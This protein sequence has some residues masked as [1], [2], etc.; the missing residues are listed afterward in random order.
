LNTPPPNASVDWLVIGSG[1]AGT[2]AARA[3]VEQGHHVTVL[4][5]G[6]RLD[7]DREKIVRRMA[8]LRPS[9]WDSEDLAMVLGRRR[10]SSEAVHSKLSYGSSY[11]FS[12]SGP[13]DLEIR[14]EGPLGCH[15]SPAKGGLSNVWGSA[16]LP[17]R[18]D[19]I[20]DWPVT[21]AELRHHYQAVLDFVPSTGI[22]DHLSEILPT[23]TERGV[24]LEPS[25]QG[26]AFLG[27]LESNHESLKQ[28]GLHAGRSRL[29]IRAQ[30]GESGCRR[31][32]LC[33]HGCPYGL[34]YST[35]QTIDDLSADGSI[36]YLSGRRVHTLRTDGDLVTVSG[37]DITAGTDFQILAKRVFLAAGVLPTA[38]IV[39]DSLELHDRPVTLKD[40]QYFIYPLF[41]FRGIRDVETEPMT[42][43]AQA[44][45]EIDDPWVSQHLVHLQIY[46]YSGFL[47][48][49]LNRTFLRLPLRWRW[50]RQFFLGRLLIAQG[51]IHS[52][53][54]GSI[55]LTLNRGIDGASALVCRSKRPLDVWVSVL[56]IGVKLLSAAWKLRA[57]PLFPGLKVPPPGAG[58][59]CGGS[60]PMKAQPST[61]ETDSLGQLADLPR[62]HIVDS[63]VLPSIAATSITLTEM[64]NA[65]RIASNA[66]RLTT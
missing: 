7:E 52:S 46:G 57:I 12:D 11:A 15:H 44:F 49:E 54:S 28:T 60:F 21:I 13:D 25:A 48:E 59:H 47:H 51:F 34:I 66:A 3:L 2:A 55:R 58:Y 32:S 23:Y 9:E 27:D 30:G 62:V 26:C 19:D 39:M 65:H 31:C 6:R 64:A 5:I 37:R 56:R 14:W 22:R 29:A 1:P 8:G 38:K 33:L 43:T 63:S 16:L 41:R 61:L 45:L 36:T 50:F 42:T 10:Q 4:D 20:H 18:E 53:E 17:Y 40:S 35:A 24:S